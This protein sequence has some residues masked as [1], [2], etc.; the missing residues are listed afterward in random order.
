MVRLA[1]AIFLV[2]AASTS[3]VSSLDAPQPH[4]VGQGAEQ[5]PTPQIR[6]AF[7]SGEAVVAG[8]A[9]VP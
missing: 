6:V 3:A 2:F 8:I 1:A 9:L 4:P 7:T 5:G